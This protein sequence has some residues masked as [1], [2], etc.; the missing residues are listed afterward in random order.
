MSHHL[1]FTYQLSLPKDALLSFLKETLQDFNPLNIMIG[2]LNEEEEKEEQK[3]GSK[4]SKTTTH[5]YVE[6]LEALIIRNFSKKKF[7]FQGAKP[8]FAKH[9]RNSSKFENLFKQKQQDGDDDDI[10]IM[11]FSERKTLIAENLHLKKEAELLRERIKT[12]E[13][14]LFKNNMALHEVLSVKQK[15]PYEN[16]G[17]QIREATVT[18]FNIA[19]KNINAIPKTATG[20][21]NIKSLELLCSQHLKNWPTTTNNNKKPKKELVVVTKNKFWG[22][23]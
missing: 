19:K 12:L 17:A 4:K 23:F 7:Q 13:E 3:D 8:I 1:Q 22:F 16:A 14:D 11:Q 6:L 10:I 21:K 2:I 20:K 15:E 5:V 9:I 18:K